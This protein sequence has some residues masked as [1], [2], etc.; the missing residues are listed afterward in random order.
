MWAL[1]AAEAGES[2]FRGFGSYRII[3]QSG[4]EIQADGDL[5]RLPVFGPWTMH[6]NNGMEMI[7]DI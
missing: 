5:S 3:R 1:V 2:R 7:P 4:N 6:L